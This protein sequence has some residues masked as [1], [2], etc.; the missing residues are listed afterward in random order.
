M[1]KISDHA[2]A[3]R[4]EGAFHVH[5]GF[6]GTYPQKKEKKRNRKK[7]NK[8]ERKKGKEKRKEKNKR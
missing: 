2:A 7:Q 6:A 8:K 3:L 5:Y 1:N 4:R